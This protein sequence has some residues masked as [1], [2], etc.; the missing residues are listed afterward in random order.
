MNKCIRCGKPTD[1]GLYEDRKNIYY[2]EHLCFDCSMMITTEWGLE[3]KQQEFMM[4]TVKEENISVMEYVAR[5]LEFRATT[6]KNMM[7]IT[8]DAE[9]ASNL[10]KNHI[11]AIEMIGDD[12]E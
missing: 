3:K 4:K 2:G 8:G 5:A 11:K 7:E 10:M 6:F 12:E 9:E 1:C